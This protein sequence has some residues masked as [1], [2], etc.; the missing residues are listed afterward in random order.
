MTLYEKTDVILNIIN[1]SISYVTLVIAIN[2]LSA[3]KQQVDYSTMSEVRTGALRQLMILDAALQSAFGPDFQTMLPLSDPYKSLIDEEKSKPRAFDAM[4]HTI[5]YANKAFESLDAIG[6]IRVFLG[7]SDKTKFDDVRGRV[8]Y[9]VDKLR[10]FAD[11]MIRSEMV[12]G[13]A[14]EGEK[15]L[16]NDYI[17]DREGRHRA[18]MSAL[19]S[20]ILAIINSLPNLSA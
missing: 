13:A 8:L 2:A 20:E 4:Y 7:H 18:Q 10:R 17:I 6:E 16:W 1:I 3:W 9:E 19:T 12:R 15:A 14:D 11:Q 5:Y